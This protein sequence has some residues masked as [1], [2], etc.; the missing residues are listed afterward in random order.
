[1]VLAGYV[2]GRNLR[3]VD[4][5]AVVRAALQNARIKHTSVAAVETDLRAAMEEATAFGD[6]GRSLPE[7]LVLHGARIADLSGLAGIDQ[8]LALA[9]EELRGRAARDAVAILT[10]PRRA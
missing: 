7:T 5:R 1:M 2:A 8:A 6:V 9:R 3:V 4:E 10:V